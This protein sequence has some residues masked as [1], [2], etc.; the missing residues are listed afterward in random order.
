MRNHAPQSFSGDDGAETGLA[1]L[2][3]PETLSARRSFVKAGSSFQTPCPI[4][5]LSTGG[6]STWS[7]GF[8]TPALKACFITQP[9]R[10]IRSLPHDKRKRSPDLP[11][12]VRS[13]CGGP[14]FLLLRDFLRGG[15]RKPLRGS[16][17]PGRGGALCEGQIRGPCRGAPDGASRS[18]G[19]SGEGTLWR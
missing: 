11:R 14:G 17:D 6:D 13:S 4:T 3:R 10:N 5:V 12:D 8:I 18:G 2:E 15:S 7:L 9:Q 1:L 16:G 19:F